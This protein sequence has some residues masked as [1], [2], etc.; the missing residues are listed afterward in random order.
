MAAGG[1]DV[2]A[3]FAAEGDGDAGAAEDVGEFFLAGGGRT[4]PR[5]AGHG[6][7]GDEVDVSVEVEGDVAEFFCLV[8]R[9]VYVLDE[10]EFEGDHA[11]VFIGESLDRGEELGEGVGLVDGHD[12]FADLVGGAVEGEGE[13]DA[14]GFVGEA[15]DFGD[16]AAGGESDAAGADAE[17]PVGVDDGEGADDGVVVGEGFAHAHDDDVVEG[18]EFHAGAGG[19]GVLAVADV[20]ELADDLAGVEVAFEAEEAGGAEFAAHGAADLGGDADGF[21]GVFEADALLGGADDDGF[22]EGAVAEFEQEFI[23]DVEG[24]FAVD[25]GE[26]DEFEGLGEPGAEGFGEVGH[27]VPRADA[28]FVEPVE[29]LAGA[30]GRFA[31]FGEAGGEGVEGLAGEGGFGGGELHDWRGV[32]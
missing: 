25:E 17:A 5:E 26:G 2:V 10:D 27:V 4:F 7:V 13:A 11:A 28:F 14:E 15:E 1:V 20:E 31:A 16:E 19:A 8:E 9:V 3:L 30:E 21:A 24:L 29:D 6:V 23:G 12:L 32:R 18:G 22:D